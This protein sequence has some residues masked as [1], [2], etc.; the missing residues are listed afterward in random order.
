MRG[1][2]ILIVVVLSVVVACGE[3]RLERG[4][5]RALSAAQSVAEGFAWTPLTNRPR[6]L[7]T[8]ITG[9]TFEKH[10]TYQIPGPFFPM[11]CGD[12]WPV[13]WA[14]DGNMYAANGDGF[15]WQWWPTDIAVSRIE[16]KPPL[17][18]GHTSPAA[19]GNMIAGKWPPR[20]KLSRKPTGMT[21]VDGKLYMFFQNLAAWTTPN[22]FGEA[23][24][25]SL[26]VSEDYGV[27]WH[28]DRARPMFT[29]YVFTTGFF[30][31]FGKCGEWA[32]D[33]YIYVYGLDY[34]WRHSPGFVQTKMFLAR[35]SPADLLRIGGWEFFT[36]LVEGEPTWSADIDDRV[37]TLQDDTE[38]GPGQGGIA[39]GSV[40]YIPALN[41]Y[42][43][44]SWADVGWMFYEAPQPWGPWT[45]VLFY[46]WNEEP[47]SDTYHGGYATVIPSKLLDEDGGGGWISASLLGAMD[48]RYY[49][50]NLRR[51]WIHTE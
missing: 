31:D 12:L 41:R 33:E 16:G 51:F 20:W 10:T 1:K 22:E 13:T 48:N 21:C 43:Y 17:M 47:M 44:S 39:Q 11:F 40:V 24:H 5:E 15:A 2:I 36:G 6:P 14:D 28:Y 49:R 4:D 37:P 7:S 50:Y 19:T 8:P 9:V 26:S 3:A 27:T 25:A 29:D 18:A 32:I 45:L 34:N 35:V 46:P 42:L 23:P 38:Y 30:L